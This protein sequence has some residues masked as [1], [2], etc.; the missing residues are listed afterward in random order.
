MHRLHTIA[1]KPYCLSPHWFKL[2][3]CVIN[4]LFS[5]MLFIHTLFLLQAFFKADHFI[6]IS[7]YKVRIA[8]SE[9]RSCH[10]T[11]IHLWIQSGAKR[12]KST[13]GR[14]Y[15]AYLCGAEDNQLDSLSVLHSS[16]FFK[17][18]EVHN[19][20]ATVRPAVRYGI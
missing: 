20:M 13:K 6:F 2:S 7:F 15:K 10:W 19:T 3:V 17:R 8:L 4:V 12:R 14:E 11:N 16:H 18:K 9:S 1:K 5:S